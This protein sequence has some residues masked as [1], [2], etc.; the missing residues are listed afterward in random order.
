MAS[1][2]FVADLATMKSALR[3]SGVPEGRDAN[4]IISDA[5]LEARVGFYRKLGE[6]RVTYLLG[7]TYTEEPSSSAERLRVIA[8]Q[9]EVKWCRLILMRTLPVMFMDGNND[10]IQSWNEES[11]FRGMTRED[12]LLETKR[13]ENEITENL[14]LLSG[15]ESF[16]NETSIR[17]TMFEPE[18]GGFSPGDTIWS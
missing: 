9:T 10:V 2:L 11:A 7:I 1:P 5:V 13:L 16:G 17:G 18:D 4:E 12:I 8:N 3:L 6:G 14:D 15:S